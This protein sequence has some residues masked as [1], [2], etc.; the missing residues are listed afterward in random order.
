MN[1]KFGDGRDPYFY[2]GIQVLR[3]KLDIHESAGLREA[4][5][6]L[7]PLRAATVELGAP[8]MGLPWLCAIHR[9]LFQDIYEWAGQLRTVDIYQNETRYCHFSYLEKEGNAVMQRLEDEDY[10][11][12]L[13][14]DEIC[15][16]LGH[17]YADINMLHPFREGNGR[18]QRI[19]FEQ[20]IIHAGFDARWEPIER[21]E[22]INANEAGAF[23]D[24]APLAAIFARVVSE[25][26]E[27]P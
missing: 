5:L 9:T 26:G 15:P 24:S 12:G 18:A 23:G 17:Y 13:A 19:F 21:E 4:E 25:P 6:A 1:D 2:P 14:L 8:N 16:R 20:L 22:W 10:L 27:Q 3:N 11:R 7:T